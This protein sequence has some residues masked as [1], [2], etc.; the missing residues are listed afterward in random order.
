MSREQEMCFTLR[1]GRREAAW[2]VRAGPGERRWM[3]REQGLPGLPA[4]CRRGGREA[5][6]AR[7]AGPRERGASDGQGGLGSPG[8]LHT[9]GEG[10]REALDGQKGGASWA[11]FTLREGEGDRHTAGGAGREAAGWPG[12]AG[13]P[14]APA[15]CRRGRERGAGWP[16]GQGLLGRGAG[17]ARMGW[18]SRAP[19]HTA[20]GGGREALDGQDGWAPGLPGS[21]QQGPV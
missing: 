13:P 4:H 16:G 3:A 12:R 1:E 2:P 7:R 15:H 21:Q 6:M 17:M 9:E 19:L 8:S 14:R 20:G 18:A 11:S 5:R 10:R